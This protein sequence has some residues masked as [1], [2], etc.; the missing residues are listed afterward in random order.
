MNYHAS[1]PF[2][3]VA[4][5]ILFS[6][7]L[8]VNCLDTRA[9]DRTVPDEMQKNA[10]Q[11]PG[12]E[13]KELPN[14]PVAQWKLNSKFF[15][16][17][18]S[19]THSGKASLRYEATE[20][21]GSGTA[22]QNVLLAE[23]GVE[24][25][26]SGWIKTRDARNPA[27]IALEFYADPRVFTKKTFLGGVYPP[28][29]KGTANWTQVK[30]RVRIP[31]ETKLTVL[32]L[33]AGSSGMTWFDDLECKVHKYVPLRT[34]LVSPHYRGW[35]VAGKDR[36]IRVRA[37]LNSAQHNFDRKDVQL[38]TQIITK[39]GTI[40]KEN[41]RLPQKDEQEISINIDELLTPG[42]FIVRVTLIHLKTSKTID[43]NEH[44]I[45][46]LEKAYNPAVSFDRHHRMLV[47]GKPF[48]P[49]G[50]CVLKINENDLKTFAES[51]FNY[52]LPLAEPDRKEMDM[53]QR[54]GIKVGFSIMHYFNKDTVEHER[55]VRSRVRQFRN[56]P[57]LLLWFMADEPASHRIAN[58]K[59]EAQQRWVEQEDR[60][61]PTALTM[62]HPERVYEYI[63]SCDTISTDPY[64]L[65]DRP[66][67]MAGKWT[68]RTTREVLH[69]RPVWMVPQMFSFAAYP[70]HPRNH[71]TP[72]VREMRCMAWQ[73]IC[74][75]ATGLCFYS[76]FDLKRDP[77][78][79]FKTQWPRCK[80]VAAEISEL[81]PVILSI[82]PVPKVQV[83][84]I[85]WLHWTAR[86]Q[87]GKLYIMAV[88]N[89]DGKGNVSF[90]VPGKYRTAKV[91]GEDRFIS[92]KQG[93]L[94]DRF[95]TMDVHIYQL[96]P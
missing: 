22:T 65:P 75:G 5:E 31:D 36:T 32:T 92:L 46:V 49:L 16:R 27:R 50:M 69:A 3:L 6:V 60:N 83:K 68:K 72:T 70:K 52:I 37:R 35:L 87:A 33:A 14:I 26:L 86:S 51:K 71:H 95:D 30:Q 94:S 76:F 54:Y 56:H 91:L 93:V 40:L 39:D 88:N 81:I 19:Q 47:E 11:N 64:P 9:A 59:I 21:K 78:T 48:F 24:Y 2:F 79:P 28:G 7:G 18:E 57:A 12:F 61:H 4:V 15:S 90:K 80:Q 77:Q 74:E 62:M 45:H 10:I 23:P 34:V 43:A 85:P 82:D 29:V 8:S 53:A 42:D 38:L 13:H 17:D 63:N 20:A 66:I 25:E 96:E 67:S 73:C 1:C 44:F 55:L 58:S 41:K 84:E 89:G